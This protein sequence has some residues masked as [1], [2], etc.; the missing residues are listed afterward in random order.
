MTEGTPGLRP[1]GDE[2]EQAGPAV[3]P[4]LPA[5]VLVRVH[6]RMAAAQVSWMTRCG[7]PFRWGIPSV[8]GRT[9]G[10][11]LHARAVLAHLR[12]PVPLWLC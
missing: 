2:P 1:A 11:K 4:G 6:G 8:R 7:M 9:F 3:L 5:G 12:L 10:A